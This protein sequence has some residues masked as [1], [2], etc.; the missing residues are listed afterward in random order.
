MIY[1]ISKS[2]DVFTCHF[3][4]QSF[5]SY[6]FFFIQ[7]L[8]TVTVFSFSIALALKKTNLFSQNI[9][10]FNKSA[11][12]PWCQP[13]HPVLFIKLTNLHIRSFPGTF[14]SARDIHSVAPDVIVRFFG[15]YNSGYHRTL[16]DSWNKKKYALHLKDLSKQENTKYKVS[17]ISAPFMF[18]LLLVL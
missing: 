11:L 7:I 16:A 9:G 3:I 15:A 18:L 4:S 12:L 14:H 10:Q 1:S 6:V 17:A 5:A 13:L 8:G 2:W